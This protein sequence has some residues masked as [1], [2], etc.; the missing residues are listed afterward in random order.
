[1]AKRANGEGSLRRK[2]NGCWE[3]Q[4]MDGFKSDGRR[5]IRSFTGRTQK[6]AKEKRDEFLQKKKPVC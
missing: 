6:E 2:E 1:M 3:I 4:I 5:N